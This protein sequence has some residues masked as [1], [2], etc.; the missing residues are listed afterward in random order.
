VKFR[1]FFTA[2]IK[3]LQDAAVDCGLFERLRLGTYVFPS[4][5]DKCAGDEV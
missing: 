4:M 2:E 3:Q 5:A 1:A